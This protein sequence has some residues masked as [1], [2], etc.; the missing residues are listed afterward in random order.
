[1]RN[2]KENCIIFIVGGVVY[3]LI[4]VLW[5]RHTH[6]S[7]V[8]TGGT[9]F[10]ALYKIYGKIRNVTLVE[11]C[12]I[13]S[14]VITLIEFL[15]GC[16]VNVWLKLNVWDYSAIPFNFLGQVCI[17]Y[18]TLWGFLCIPINSLC[19]KITKTKEK[20]SEYTKAA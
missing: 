19:S 1:M 15:V 18:S 10:L 9:C 5:R 7:M 11:K 2:L 3:G 20:Y 14:V 4:E 16:V 6:W 12:V 8:L 13:G 17:L